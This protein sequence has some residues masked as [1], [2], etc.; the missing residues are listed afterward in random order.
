MATP[1]RNK[2]DGVLRNLEAITG[3]L[4]I[5]FFQEV[6]REE[7]EVGIC[8]GK[9]STFGMLKRSGGDFMQCNYAVLCTV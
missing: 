1:T 8:D 2:E 6:K 5:F 3:I 9:A 4:S 7:K